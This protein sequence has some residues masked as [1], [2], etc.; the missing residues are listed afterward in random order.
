MTT[1]HSSDEYCAPVEAA[2]RTPSGDLV[3]RFLD[4]A[5]P[6][7]HVRGGP[8]HVRARHTA[9][10]LLA[11]YPEIAHANFQT[12]VV[13]GDLTAVERALATQPELATRR[14]ADPDPD[15]SGVGNTDDLV[16][17]RLGRKGWDPLLYLCFTRLPLVAVNENALSI[18]RLLLDH[19]ADPRA[20]FMAGDSHYTPL[21][22]AI[23]EGEEDRPP[24]PQR[25]A[26]VRL[27]LERGADP[28]DNQVVYNI[29]FHADVLW[30]LELSYARSV[31]LGRKA[32][33]DDPEW[34]MLN[35]GNYGSGAAWHLGMAI[36][37]DDARLAEWCLVHGASSDPAPPRD[38]R[39]THR[40]LYDEAVRR[41]RFTIA[42]LLVR[43]GAQRTEVILQPMEDFVQA[44][45]R[46]DRE[47][48]RSWLAAHPE[49][50]RASEPLFAAAKEDRDDVVAF[51]L[52]LGMSPDVES[53]GKERPLHI[54]AYRNALRVAEL[55][56]A[57]G[58]DVDAV[59]SNWNNTPLGAAVYAQH[60]EMIELLARHSRDVWEL[61]YTGSIDRLR[62][63]LAASPERSRVVSGG[64]TPLMWLPPEDE[65]RALEVARLLI[66]HGSDPTLVNKDGM[67][68][69]DR[70][71]RLGMFDVASFLRG[72]AVQMT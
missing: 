3:A 28:Y 66:A 5:C 4:V 54:A 11:R 13:C 2:S 15:R 62:E 23:G 40:S 55:L 68:A 35:M 51:L 17:R 36:R 67:T 10:R 52:D 9:M 37:H 14:E 8:D 57:R 71:E 72:T 33:W 34:S 18:A 50:L 16:R 41:G 60:Q 53:S 45:L 65:S 61:V 48:I 20:Y 25:D 49:F 43:Y 30:F 64:H 1:P 12:A 59:E 6:D 38:K 32:D 7:H 42:E 39:F 29:H 24:H 21:V 47:A 63:V 27:L 56:I 58:A 22:G 19:G 31:E 26:L 46:L 70:A 44:C 69:A